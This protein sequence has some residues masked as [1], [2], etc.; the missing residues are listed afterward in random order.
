MAKFANDEIMARDVDFK[1]YATFFLFSI[2]VGIP[3]TFLTPFE[4]PPPTLAAM[5]IP[6]MSLALF[7]VFLLE[8]TISF[9]ILLPRISRPLGPPSPTS[10][11]PTFKSSVVNANGNGN[12]NDNDENAFTNLS[13]TRGATPTLFPVQMKALIKISIL[14]LP[15]PLLH[16]HYPHIFPEFTA[17]RFANAVL[18]HSQLLM[19]LWSPLRRSLTFPGLV[20]STALGVLLYTTYGLSGW[21]I[22]S[23]YFVLGSAVTKIRYSEKENLGIAESRGGRRGPENVFGSAGVGA[24]L[25]SWVL[26]KC[27]S[28]ELLAVLKIGYVACFATKLSDTFASEIGKAYG[29]KTYSSIPP[30][31]RVNAGTE[32]AVSLEGTLGGVLGAFLLTLYGS[33]IG[34]L[35]SS[36]LAMGVVIGSSVFATFC[37]SWIG[38][39]AQNKVRI[40]TNEVVN[41]LNTAIGA[42]MA[43]GLTLQ[44]GL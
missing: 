6:K 32:G 36:A 25:S 35:P 41:F 11:P 4:N 8:T 44:F 38:A 28:P 43:V 23:F 30:F 9:P 29:T 24:L 3:Y 42:I 15:P 18:F 5:Q 34:F 31:R 37:E 39:T 14:L 10:L 27:P 1:K 40:L 17:A 19:T 16:T 26:M 33:K 22:G 2:I 13:E 20:T 12:D 21:S 7:A